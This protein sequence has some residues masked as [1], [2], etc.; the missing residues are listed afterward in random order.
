MEVDF[1]VAKEL[2]KSGRG[3]LV[4]SLESWR[5]PRAVSVAWA[6]LYALTI[7]WAFRLHGLREDG[8][9]VVVV[10]GQKMVVAAE[11]GTRKQ[12]KWLV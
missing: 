8:V 5:R 11:E 7:S 10:N 3:F 12:P 6:R 9:A 2:F 4:Y 1:L